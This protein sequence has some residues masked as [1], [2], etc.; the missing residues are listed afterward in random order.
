MNV[1]ISNAF[2]LNMLKEETTV[3]EIKK[4]SVEEVKKILDSA[5]NIVSAVGH[6]STATVL[7]Y[8]LGREIN[9]NRISITLEDSNTILVV[10]Q[11]RCR[12]EEGRILS[13]K[14][15]CELPYE[16]FIVRL[17]NK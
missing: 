16:F 9:A 17:I 10:F 15:I 7:S 6:I 8:L 11:L 4:I 13:E 3:L 1:I 14:E 12:L 5:Q 2:S